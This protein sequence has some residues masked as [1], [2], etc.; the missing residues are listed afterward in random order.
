MGLLAIPDHPILGSKTQVCDQATWKFDVETYHRFSTSDSL[1]FY[2][3][4]EPSGT[5][6]YHKM[7]IVFS[8]HRKCGPRISPEAAEKLKNRYVLMRTGARDHENDTNKRINIPITVRYF[9]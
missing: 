1:S 7:F 2:Q 3:P 4:F 6:P 9:M 5:K 8:S